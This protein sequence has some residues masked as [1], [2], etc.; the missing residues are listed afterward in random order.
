[1]AATESLRT[2][3]GVLA[4]LEYHFEIEADALLPVLRRGHPGSALLREAIRQHTPQLAKTRSEL[5]R[6][7]ADFLVERRFK[8]PEFNHPVG[9]S[10]V[11]A[12]YPDEKVV[13]ELDGV[14]GHKAERRILRDHQRDL[15]RRADGFL[16]LRYHLAQI[17][18]HPDLVDSDLVGA[19]IPRI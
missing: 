9:Q 19:G 7:F 12:V 16:P 3:K 15:H 5:E 4:E 13:I 14:Q 10:T 6:V 2:V 1:M 8:L 17:R 18:L 11:D